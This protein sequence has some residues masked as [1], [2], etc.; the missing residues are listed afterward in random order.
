MIKELPC[1][2]GCTDIVT[3]ARI[4]VYGFYDDFH[5]VDNIDVNVC[6]ECGKEIDIAFEDDED[7][8]PC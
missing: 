2:C 6:A 8:L 4:V 7:T 1:T 3:E 5:D